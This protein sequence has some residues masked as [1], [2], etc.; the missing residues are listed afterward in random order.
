MEPN[1]F[2]QHIKDQL[3]QRKIEPSEDAWQKI[4]NQLDQTEKP[5]T[6]KYLWLGVA[7]SIVGLLIITTAYF[8]SDKKLKNE[9]TIVNSKKDSIEKNQLK[10]EGVFEKTKE[11]LTSTNTKNIEKVI[12]RNLKKIKP[13]E[14]TPIITIENKIASIDSVVKKNENNI[15]TEELINTKLTEVIAK[16]TKIEQNAE[17]LTDL[18]VDSLITQAQ[19]ELLNQ[20]LFRQNKS[21]DAMI[22]L[23][24]IENELDKPLKEQI[25]ELLKKGVLEARNA[26]AER[27]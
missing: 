18:E 1:K 15:N 26:V 19:K 12:S 8:N 7:A 11:I 2:E 22:L 5:K 17:S 24:E 9:T 6:K 13:V 21:V 10:T 23:S 20:K 16:I 14:T 4:A 27:N 3:N 25:F